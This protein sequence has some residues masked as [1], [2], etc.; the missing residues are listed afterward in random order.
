MEKG[1]KYKF[2]FQQGTDSSPE[3]LERKKTCKKE[4]PG[5]TNQNLL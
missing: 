2:L 3:Q 5:C 1:E 4:G